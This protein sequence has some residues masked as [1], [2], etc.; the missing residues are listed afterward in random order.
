MAAERGGS[1]EPSS[2]QGE[3]WVGRAT[4]RGHA[5]EKKSRLCA[6]HHRSKIGSPRRIRK[7][8]ASRQE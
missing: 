3:V 4:A 8:K 1:G 2:R 5:E 7:R 6:G